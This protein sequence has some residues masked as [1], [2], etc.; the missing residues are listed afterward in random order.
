MNWKSLL[1]AQNILLFKNSQSK[2]YNQTRQIFNSHKT[3]RKFTEKKNILNMEN[4]VGRVHTDT[5]FCRQP[6][7]KPM[8]REQYSEFFLFCAQTCIK[9]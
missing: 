5:S 1:N 4:K 7:I 9:K 2:L 3:D 6:E 8:H